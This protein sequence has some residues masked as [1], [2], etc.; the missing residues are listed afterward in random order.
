[1]EFIAPTENGKLLKTIKKSVAA[2]IIIMAMKAKELV[3]FVSWKC[4]YR[5]ADVLTATTATA[6]MRMTIYRVTDANHKIMFLLK[7]LSKTYSSLIVGII[8]FVLI[9]GSNDAQRVRRKIF[10][11][12]IRMM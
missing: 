4:L 7:H 10:G 8:T 3:A 11:D 1:M 5:I 2:K 6:V 12:T 9:N